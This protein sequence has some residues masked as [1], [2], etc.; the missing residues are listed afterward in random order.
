MAYRIG[1]VVLGKPITDADLR[2][3]GKVGLPYR[4]C[5][6][7]RVR[8]FRVYPTTTG[9]VTQ[10]LGEDAQRVTFTGE[11]PAALEARTHPG[12]GKLVE[13]LESGETVALYETFSS[14]PP[15]N[16]RERKLG[17]FIV[18]LVDPHYSEP[19]V[20]QPQLLR[21]TVRLVQE[22]VPG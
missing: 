17:D 1:E 16:Y 11:L 7:P 5:V 9:H 4:D 14:V 19:L 8:R 20:G 18:V 6:R 22:T 2:G 21:W 3:S 12:L 10:K 15:Y 13:Y